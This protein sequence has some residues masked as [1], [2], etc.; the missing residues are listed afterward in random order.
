METFEGVTDA[1]TLS[2][3]TGV[4]SWDLGRIAAASGPRST[5]TLSSEA[6]PSSGHALVSADSDASHAPTLLGLSLSAREGDTVL[7]IEERIE[8]I[9]CQL[10]AECLW[11]CEGHSGLLEGQ[12]F[13]V[14]PSA[15]SPRQPLS[16]PLPRRLRRPALSLLPQKS[17]RERLWWRHTRR[18]IFN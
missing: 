16:L 2:S 18:R 3:D 5:A 7:A 1:C 11:R 17:W 8:R 10:V 12:R 6:F 15:P 14:L 4:E 13:L 9:V